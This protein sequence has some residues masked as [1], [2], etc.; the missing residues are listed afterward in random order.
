MSWVEV[1]GAGWS[2]VEVDGAGQRWVY[3]LPIP[4][5]DMVTEKAVSRAKRAH[6]LTESAL[7]IKLPKTAL[8][9]EDL[10]DEN[11][12][13]ELT[14]C[15]KTLFKSALKNKEHEVDL[16]IPELN[17]FKDFI[18]QTKSSL[19]SKSRTT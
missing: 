11:M 18:D 16:Q 6:L 12:S 14:D 10:L 4:L 7:M 5:K 15:I 2:W 1:D 3:G 9:T 8:T 13:K 17:S 19:I